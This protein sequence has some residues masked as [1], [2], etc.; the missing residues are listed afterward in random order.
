MEERP[1][2]KTY[3]TGVPAN[4]DADA[5]PNLLSLFEETMAKYKKQVAF[6]CMDK[7]FTFDAVDKMSQRFGAYLHSRGLEPGDRIA[8]MMPNLLHRR[9]AVDLLAS[10]RA[11]NLSAPA[12]KLVQSIARD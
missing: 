12:L 6:I 7:P 2:L 5:Y 4:I 11:D 10:D 1:W 3:P 9:E 8:L